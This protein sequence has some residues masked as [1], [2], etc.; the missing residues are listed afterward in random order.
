MARRGWTPNSLF[1]KLEQTQIRKSRIHD[2]YDA[3]DVEVSS[4]AE[5]AKAHVDFYTNLFSEEPIDLD[6]QSDLLSSS[7]NSLF[8]DQSMLCEGQITLEEITNAVKGLKA[9]ANEDTLLRT[10]CCRHKCFPVCPLAQHLL[11]TQILCPGHKK[12]FWFCSETFCVRNKC[13]PVCAAQETSWATMC[14]R[15]PGP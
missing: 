4:Q 7:T 15:L 14:P 5:I 10:H 11:R 9:L 2:I 12:C 1:F 3:N 6:K 8:A 13:F